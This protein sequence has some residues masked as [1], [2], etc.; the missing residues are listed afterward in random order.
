MRREAPRRAAACGFTLVEMLVVVLII[1]LMTGVAVLSLSLADTHPARDR[2]RQL[3]GLV[4]IAG[5]EAGL[6][7]ENLALG[8]WRRGW[9]FYVLRGGASWQ[10]LTGDTL[11]RPRTLPAGLSLSLELQGQR[12]AL[13]DRDATRPQVFLLASGEMQPFVVE[14]RAAGHEPV[15]VRGNAIGEVSVQ[16]A[17]RGAERP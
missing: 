10:P 7:G 6:Q 17:G 3:A 11:L 5:E 12:V 15:R 13:E 8:F 4:R 1:G 9:R 14:L 2:A 16:F